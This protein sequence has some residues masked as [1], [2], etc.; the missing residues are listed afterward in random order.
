MR[1]DVKALEFEKILGKLKAFAKTTLAKNKISELMPTNDFQEVQ[2]RNEETKEAFSALVHLSDIPLG[3]LY[4]I[5][6]SI[7]RAK[8]GSV[9]QP[10]ELLNVVGLLDCGNSVERYFKSLV[11][12]KENTPHLDQYVS[13]LV[14]FPTLK[15]NI[16]LAISADAKVNDNASRELFTIRRSISS[17][18]NRLRSK[19]NEL[20]NTK[21]SN[22]TENLIVM[23][24]NRMCL[25]VKIEYK[26]SFKGIVHDISSSNTTCYIEPEA[27]VETS[28]QID[29]YTAAE[30]K[31]VEI[32][33][34]N[35]SL[36]VGSEADGLLNNLY[37]LTDLDIIFAKAIMARENDY[38]PVKITEDHCFNIKKAKHPLIPADQV[39]PIDISLGQKHSTIIITGPN[40]GGKTV[41]LKT[42]GLL[43]TMM[44]CGLMVPAASD[45]VLSVFS[46]ILVDIGD[47]QSI[48]Q[49][50][51]TFSA[52]MT[53]MIG[54]LAQT[55]FESLI[56]LDELGSGTDPKEGSSLAIAMI[57]YMKKRG[58]KIIV[59]T[60][61]SDLKTYAY[62]NEDI[63]NASVEFNTNT[64]LPTY[65]LLI[66]VPGRSN[67]IEIASRLGLE[68]SIIEQSKKYMAATETSSGNL[69]ANLE[70]EMLKIR[71]KEEVL[72]H[73]IEVYEGLSN[74][75]SLEKLNLTK[76]SDQI[77]GKA[78]AEAS[79]IVASSKEEAQELLSQIKLLSKD[80]YKEHELADLKH[81][82]R[83]LKVDA[84]DEVLFDEPLSVNDYV[85]IKPY[86]KNG[87]ITK[88]KKDI[89]T[90]QMGQFSMDFSKKDLVKAAKPKDKPIKQIRMS[91]YHPSA[92]ASLS[93]DLRGKRF[94]EVEYLMDQ[95]LDQ[96]ILGNY[97]QVSIIHGFGTG[98][99][100]NAVQ[101]YLKKCPY[102]KS[103]RYG[104]EGEGLNGVTVV[105]LK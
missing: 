97:E 40:T 30:K 19:L 65:R 28:N 96:A 99:I 75:L 43:H 5:E 20:L 6:K 33:L 45:S 48:E 82:V 102:V 60:H 46:E 71:E 76:Q 104:Q 35:L 88:I 81:K 67:A 56:L 41:A 13:Q 54:I 86:E 12:I 3:G 25:P 17:L 9:L 94:E 34:R 22:L 80:D 11:A 78:K 26:N 1:Y 72:A 53:K 21:A 85:Y 44:M 70:E 24:N 57:D 31:E 16:T 87:T 64:L 14:S 4:D 10:E 66:G 101:A 38:Y 103:Y 52:H 23:R 49:S 51:S 90:V 91:G 63:Q 68:A 74:E 93:L 39:V 36:L 47:E 69:L 92:S 50:L 73:K 105:K 55:S 42:V 8:V 79:K 32:I 83:N 29:S 58:A 2:K 62:N 100:R 7:L 95:Y 61:Y 27:T 18:Q 37:A 98:V 89:Y 59:T 15:T 77:I 84:K